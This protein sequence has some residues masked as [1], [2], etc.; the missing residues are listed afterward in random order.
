M[1]RVLYPMACAPRR[2]ELKMMLRTWAGDFAEFASTAA[3][4][5]IVR[6]KRTNPVFTN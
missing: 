6:T 3:A 1:D 5:E 4:A 2:F